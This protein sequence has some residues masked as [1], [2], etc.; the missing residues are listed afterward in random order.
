MK[1]CQ[2]TG[3]CQSNTCTG[4]DL[5]FLFLIEADKRPEDL[6]FHFIGNDR[7]IVSCNDIECLI[8]PV[9]LQFDVHISIGILHAVIQQV[10]DNFR[11]GFTID[12][13]IENL[14]RLFQRQFNPLLA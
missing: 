7:P 11:K 9:H 14:I 10:T 2:R 1:L 13:R 12:M 6:F 8:F 4:S 3:Q 5:P